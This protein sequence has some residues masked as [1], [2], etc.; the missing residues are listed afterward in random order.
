[1]FKRGLSLAIVAVMVSTLGFASFG[2][3]VK[4]Q[5]SDEDIAAGIKIESPSM[6]TVTSDKSDNVTIS[7]TV[8]TPQGIS[9]T[10]SLSRM[11]GKELIDSAN[12][13]KWPSIPEVITKKEYDSERERNVVK[14]LEK[15]YEERVKADLAYE[16][17]KDAYEKAKKDNK[18]TAKL[19]ELKEDLDKAL[20]ALSEAYGEYQNAADA[21]LDM[22]TVYIF[23]DEGVGKF[24]A[25]NRTFKAQSGFYKLIFKRSDNNRVVKVLDFEVQSTEGLKNIIQSSD[26]GKK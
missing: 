23:E 6:R 3:A 12:K 4:K 20:K 21:Y 13:L 2:E 19:S 1:M 7:G 11:D 8:T 17:A 25:I 14:K 5:V 10:I 16:K 18:A 22:T 15:T 24:S 9:V 26:G